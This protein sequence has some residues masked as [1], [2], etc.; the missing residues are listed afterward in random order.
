MLSLNITEPSLNSIFS[1]IGQ[2]SEEFSRSGGHKQ[3]QSGR[4]DHSKTG[5]AQA[6]RDQ[7]NQNTWDDSKNDYQEKPNNNPIK[8]DFFG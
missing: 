2:R 8:V 5:S 6:K 3:N 4:A 1:F 7:R